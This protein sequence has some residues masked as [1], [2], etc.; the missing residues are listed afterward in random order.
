V[1]RTT[2]HIPLPD[3]RTTPTLRVEEAGILLQFGRAKAYR[4]AARYLATNGSEGLP[5]LAFG[6]SLRVPTAALLK[7]L[8]IESAE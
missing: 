8:G 7:L 3:P 2:T 1:P 4:E 5:V 6:R